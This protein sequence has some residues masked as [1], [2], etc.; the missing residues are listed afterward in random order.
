MENRRVDGPVDDLSVLSAEMPPPGMPKGGERSLTASMPTATLAEPFTRALPCASQ[1]AHE[2][3]ASELPNTTSPVPSFRQRL[4]DVLAEGRQNERKLRRFQSLELRLI[5][6][7]SLWELIEALLYP[8]TVNFQWDTVTLLLVDPEYEVRRTLEQESIPVADHPTLIFV[9]SLDSLASLH[10]YSLFPMLGPFQPNRHHGLFPP[11]RRPASVALLPMVRYGKLIGSLNI[12]SYNRER[13]VKGMRADILEHFAAIVAICLENAVNLERLKRQGLTDTLTAVNNRRFF[14][15][16][17]SEEV[18]AAQRNLRP[19]SC[20]LLDIDHFKRVNDT[21]GHQMGDQVLREIAAVIRAQLRSGDVLARYG[22]EEFSV[23]L[24]QTGA[25]GA[26]EIA[27]RIRRSIEEHR[28]AL[29]RN[30][31][32]EV[33]FSVTISIGIATFNP[34]H[35]AHAGKMNGDVLLGYSD[36]AMYDA[37]ARGRNRVVG[38]GDV[39]QM[40]QEV[41]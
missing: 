19:L 13:F 33:Q 12:G 26:L 29:P 14:D 38:V 28:F 5:G 18:A 35:D 37:K 27:E 16:R 3:P 4:D 34:E 1:D 17:L 11:P 9:S 32:G 20:M 6:L 24:S 22:G 40:A 10:P 8:D 36:R 39:V 2:L 7:G 25:D 21:Y 15:Q 23:L 30:E 31:Q 41:W